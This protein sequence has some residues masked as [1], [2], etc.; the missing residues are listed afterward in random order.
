MKFFAMPMVRPMD[1]IRMD[2]RQAASMQR[3]GAIPNKIG[4]GSLQHEIN[5]IPIMRMQ[6]VLFK[7]YGAKL[8]MNGI[9][10]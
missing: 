2:D 6:H 5:F 9:G 8:T 3:I 1:H 7:R 4:A 10:G